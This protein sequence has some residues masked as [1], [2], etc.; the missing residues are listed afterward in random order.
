M[1][2]SK[3]KG[4]I[5]QGSYPNG[6]FHWF[7]FDFIKIRSSSIPSA[8]FSNCWWTS[9][10]SRVHFQSFRPLNPPTTFRTFRRKIHKQ[11]LGFKSTRRPFI[12]GCPTILGYFCLEKFLK[13]VHKNHH[14]WL[15]LCTHAPTS[16]TPSLQHACRSKASAPTGVWALARIR[17]VNLLTYDEKRSSVTMKLW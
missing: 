7:L 5:E 17:Q 12:L 16:R 2:K 14:D 6:Y 11:L 4:N 8:F 3:G 13:S 10:C 9:N 15:G 1:L